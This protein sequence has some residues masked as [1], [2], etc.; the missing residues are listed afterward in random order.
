LKM[1]QRRREVGGA[2]EGR[3]SLKPLPGASVTPRDHTAPE[4]FR[5]RV[6]LGGRGEREKKME[7]QMRAR[8]SYEEAD[9][10]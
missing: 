1:E 7:L 8:G 4:G 9:I 10:A 6:V 2:E 5:R 3:H